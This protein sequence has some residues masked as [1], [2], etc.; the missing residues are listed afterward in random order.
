MLIKFLKASLT[1]KLSKCHQFPRLLFVLMFLFK[2]WVW[3][4]ERKGHTLLYAIIT[5]PSKAN[6][7]RLGLGWRCCSVLLSVPLSSPRGSP[8]ALIPGPSSSHPNSSPL[9]FS[10][11]SHRF[12]FPRKNLLYFF[13]CPP[14]QPYMY[15]NFDCIKLWN[16]LLENWQ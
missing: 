7:C 1:P 12:I 11:Y 4:W 13:S 15:F 2:Y 14:N 9:E 5:D 10:C 6:Q 3:V 8:A 16:R